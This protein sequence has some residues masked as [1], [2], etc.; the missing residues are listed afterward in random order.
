MMTIA[1]GNAMQIA[2]LAQSDGSMLFHA[3][4]MTRRGPIRPITLERLTDTK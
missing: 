4:W 2:T 3:N 1:G